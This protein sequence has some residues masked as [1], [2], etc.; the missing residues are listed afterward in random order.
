VAASD[1]AMTTCNALTQGKN[2]ERYLASGVNLSFKE[3][4]TLQKEIG[5]YKQ[6]LIK[7]PDFLLK[8]VGK[9]G[10]IIRRFGIKTEVCSMNIRQL[11]VQEYYS[12]SKA[13]SELS[14]PETE[15]KTAIGEALNWF[16]ETGKIK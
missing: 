10:D 12:N 4:Y 3:F 1:V 9:V 15:L 11:L 8:V 2:G 13:K 7:L 5:K 16:K 14:M 6:L